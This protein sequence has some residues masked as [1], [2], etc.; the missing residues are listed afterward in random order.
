MHFEDS[1]PEGEGEE[2]EGIKYDQQQ[3]IDYIA[4]TLLQGNLTKKNFLT[5][6]CVIEGAFI[7]SSMGYEVEPEE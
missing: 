2:I 3:R 6:I 7:A 4:D 1:V 5:V